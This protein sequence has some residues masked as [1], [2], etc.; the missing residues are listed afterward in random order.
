MT[1][2]R[3]MTEADLSS[4]MEIIGQAQKF[5][6]AQGIEQ[7]QNG[8]PDAATMRNDIEKEQGYIFE[9]EG[10]AAGI[11]TIALGGEPNYDKI[12]DG[13]WNTEAPYAC[14]HRMAVA[15]VFRGKSISDAMIRAAEALI[16]NRGFL[17]IRVDTHRQNSRMQR[18]L[19]RNGFARR[20]VIY[21]QNRMDAASERIAFDKYIGEIV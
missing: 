8:Y 17:S 20:G 15:E 14:I 1:G 3:A 2:L 10:M 11:I 5:L 12:Y 13:R 7:W 9:S 4:V 19:L 18:M 16:R 21:L 6:A